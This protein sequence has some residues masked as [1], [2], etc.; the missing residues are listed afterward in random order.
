MQSL[1]VTQNPYPHLNLNLAENSYQYLTP[2][3]DPKYD[4]KYDH[5][6]SLQTFNSCSHSI[7]FIVERKKKQL[8]DNLKVTPCLFFALQCKPLNVIALGQTQ[9]DNINGMT[10][11]TNFSYS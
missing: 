11:I 7:I 4:P 6:S 8:W 2:K 9:T 10:K 1:N 5:E 3:T